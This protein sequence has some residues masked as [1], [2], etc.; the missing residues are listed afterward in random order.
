VVQIR[1]TNTLNFFINSRNRINK[2]CGKKSAKEISYNNK[3][4]SAKNKYSGYIYQ[5]GITSSVARG[6]Y[7]HI[8]LSRFIKNLSI[9]VL[10][11]AVYSPSR[12]FSH[13]FCI[14]L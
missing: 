1:S 3:G 11:I 13:Y 4:K 6:N 5:A 2:P 9:I 10:M 12:L 8:T 14:K 7:N